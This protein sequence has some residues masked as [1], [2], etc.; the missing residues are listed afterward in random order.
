MTVSGRRDERKG[1]EGTFTPQSHSPSWR[2][3]PPESFLCFLLCFVPS[4]VFPVRARD[5]EGDETVCFRDRASKR[6]SKIAQGNLINVRIWPVKKERGIT[7]RPRPPYDSE[8]T[9][10][11][12][13]GTQCRP[14]SSGLLSLCASLSYKF[15]LLQ[16]APSRSSIFVQVNSRN[17]TSICRPALHLHFPSIQP[18]PDIVESWSARERRRGRLSKLYPSHYTRKSPARRRSPPRTSYSRRNMRREGRES[19]AIHEAWISKLTA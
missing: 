8:D 3:P 11:K 19:R 14:F 9:V 15:P 1:D 18:I 4:R 13:L 2:L 5:L 12:S 17:L 16:R 6:E 10:H 7:N